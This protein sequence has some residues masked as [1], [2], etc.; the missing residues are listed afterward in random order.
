MSV[1]EDNPSI[2]SNSNSHI[3]VMRNTSSNFRSNSTCMRNNTNSSSSSIN[4]N[5]SNSNSS[6]HK[7][8]SHTIIHSTR[9]NHDRDSV[10]GRQL[11]IA[12]ET[13]TSVPP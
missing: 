6:I 5:N 9:K 4:I 7:V 12:C 11:L 3:L 13:L 10:P 2:T 8:S 1:S